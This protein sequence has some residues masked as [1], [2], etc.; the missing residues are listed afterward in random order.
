M[1]V[2]I[3]GPVAAGD[4]GAMTLVLPHPLRAGETVFVEVTMGVVQR[5]Q[6]VDVTTA[7]GRLIG[8]V[9]PF[10]IRTGQAAG[11]YTIPVPPDAIDDGKLSLRLRISRPDGPPRPPTADEVTGVTLAIA[12]SRP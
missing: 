4:D 6:E 8:T 7:D 1:L 10:G 3:A 2:F 11:T 12:G 5:G 9:S